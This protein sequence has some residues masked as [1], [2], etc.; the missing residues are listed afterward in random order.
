MN[1]ETNNVLSLPVDLVVFSKSRLIFLRPPSEA[2]WLQL[3]RYL[4]ATRTVSLRWTADWRREGRSSFGDEVVAAAEGQL[5]LEFRDLRAAE[6]LEGMESRRDGLA[7]AH[8]FVVAKYARPDEQESWL[9][10]AESEELSPQDLRL[11]IEAGVVTRAKFAP[12]L[13]GNDKSAGLISI[14]GIRGQFDLWRNKVS[15]DGFPDRWDERRLGM[16]AALL[17]PMMDVYLEVQAARAP[18]AKAADPKK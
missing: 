15:E 7:D 10:L 13:S 16:V 9:D 18:E 2:E 6:A 3:G 4:K 17:R 12:K 8:H 14:E 5:E 1:K 11:S